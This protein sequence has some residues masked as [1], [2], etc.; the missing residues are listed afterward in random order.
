[1]NKIFIP[2][3]RTR[4]VRKQHI[5][6]LK[7]VNVKTSTFGIN[8]TR[9]LGPKVWNKLP[10]HM[11]C[12][13]S[14][15]IN[16]LSIP[17]KLLCCHVFRETEYEGVRKLSHSFDA[18]CSCSR[19]CKRNQCVSSLPGKCAGEEAF[20]GTAPTGIMN[21]LL[22]LMLHLIYRKLKQKTRI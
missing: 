2:E 21:Q 15:S 17:L 11:K 6:N 7:T 16:Q 4:P 9:S 20:H 1:M 14:L 18:R 19:C 13:E 5:N 22:Y 12:N 3:S 10:F 8:G